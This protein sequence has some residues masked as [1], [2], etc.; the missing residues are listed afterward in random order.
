MDH[1]NL[2]GVYKQTT[3][4]EITFV[5]FFMIFSQTQSQKLTAEEVLELLNSDGLGITDSCRRW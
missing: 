3:Q 5:S 2:A 1:L 4:T